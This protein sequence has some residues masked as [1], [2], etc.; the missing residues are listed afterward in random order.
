MA[1]RPAPNPLEIQR[2]R[3]VTRTREI[4]NAHPDWKM[5]VDT[6]QTD[7]AEAVA[8]ASAATSPAQLGVLIDIEFDIH[9][10]NTKDKNSALIMANKDYKQP[11]IV[12]NE[13]TAKKRTHSVVEGQKIRKRLE[14]MREALKLADSSGFRHLQEEAAVYMAQLRYAISVDTTV[15]RER[16]DEFCEDFEIILDKLKQTVP[17]VLKNVIYG[18]EKQRA[19]ADEATKRP[20]A[21]QTPLPESPRQKGARVRAGAANFLNTLNTALAEPIQFPP[22]TKVDV[23]SAGYQR[24]ISDDVKAMTDEIDQVLEENVEEKTERQPTDGLSAV[25]RAQRAM[26]DSSDLLGK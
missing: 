3:N 13:R 19:A 12:I 26:D 7:I 18:D 24:R 11:H 17:Q 23:F 25:K 5:F 16:P 20:L 14:A 2:K 22:G 21:E 15:S 4:I 8:T 10:S 6:I 9:R 1:E